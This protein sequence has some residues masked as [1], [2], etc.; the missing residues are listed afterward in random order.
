[1][2]I[3]IKIGAGWVCLGIIALTLYGTLK[4]LEFLL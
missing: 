2:E 3:T 1:M 4:V